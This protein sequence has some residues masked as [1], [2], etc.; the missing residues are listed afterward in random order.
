MTSITDENKKMALYAQVNVDYQ[1]NKI[2]S[3]YNIKEKIEK[4]NL[5]VVGMIFDI[6]CVYGEEPACVYIT[7]INGETDIQKIKNLEISSKIK[8]NMYSL[9]FKRL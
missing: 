1:I 5:Y 6:H 9:K 7:N 2:L 3:D 8:N 4:Q